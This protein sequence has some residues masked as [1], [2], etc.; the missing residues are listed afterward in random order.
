MPFQGMFN[1]VK[2]SHLPFVP[3][4]AVQEV[5]NLVQDDIHVEQKAI[6]IKPNTQAPGLCFFSNNLHWK[7]ILRNCCLVPPVQLGFSTG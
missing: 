1:H 5:L 3:S 6:T 7:T 2:P 4:S